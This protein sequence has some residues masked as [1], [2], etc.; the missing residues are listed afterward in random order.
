[1]WMF[2]QMCL[3]LAQKRHRGR[4]RPFFQNPIVKEIS[5][6][7]KIGNLKHNYQDCP[8]AVENHVF[9]NAARI[10]A[11]HK[12]NGLNYQKISCRE[13]SQKMYSDQSFEQD[14]DSWRFKKICYVDPLDSRFMN[15]CHDHQ[16][17][18]DCYPFDPTKNGT[19]GESIETVVG[20]VISKAE[21]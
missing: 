20:R 18:K 16:G 9:V 12:N 2:F 8:G 6:A 3:S 11:H 10:I 15:F 4:F 5:D 19:Q 14:V 1:M 17:I 21:W 7:I 13:I